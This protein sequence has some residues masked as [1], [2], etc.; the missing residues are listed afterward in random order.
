MNNETTIGMLNEL[1]L[2]G[3]ARGLESRLA[4]P[5]QAELT[6]GEF[7]G[8][9]VQDEKTERDNRRLQRLLKNARLKL[10]ACMENINY[11]HQRG[12]HKQVM[13]ELG[14]PDWIAAGRTVILTGSTGVGKSYIACALGNMAARAGHTVA[15]LRANR[16]FE[17]LATARADDSHPR[18]MQKYARTGLLIIDDLLITP[19]KDAAR[20]DLLDIIEDRYGSGATVI[21]SQCPTREWHPNIGDPTIADAICDRLL[22]TAYKIELRGESMRKNQ[23]E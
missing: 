6:H 3:M 22:H 21:T 4:D 14:R 8:L 20:G 2:F 7:V 11:R 10:E 16:L 18:L 17:A 23:A 12:L 19:L 9:L 13:L 5:K 1:K 15:Y